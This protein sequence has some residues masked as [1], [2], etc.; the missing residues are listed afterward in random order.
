[1]S[2]DVS[3][4]ISVIVVVG[5][6]SFGHVVCNVFQ[7]DFEVV[8]GMFVLTLGESTLLASEVCQCPL[9]SELGVEFVQGVVVVCTTSRHNFMSCC[10]AAAVF[11][12]VGHGWNSKSHDSGSK[13][14]L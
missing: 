1:M 3:H 9:L 4:A 2:S 11:A 12:K 5:L 13:T 6:A 7:A 14:L 8:P 10:A